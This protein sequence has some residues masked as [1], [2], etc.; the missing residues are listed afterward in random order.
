MLLVRHALT[1][2][3]VLAVSL[4]F[5]TMVGS[6]PASAAPTYAN[7]LESSVV[8][9]TNSTR[10]QHG[11]RGVSGNAC[12]DRMAESW[13]RHLAQTRTLA[14]RQL[15]RVLDQCNRSFVSENLAKYPVTPGMTATQ[16]ARSTVRAWL[17]SPAHRHNLLSFKPRVIGLGV[18]KG[19][20]GRYWYIV[21]NFAR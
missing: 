16:M 11:R 7:R 19:S 13:A 6:S 4:G 21:Q 18:A 17:R 3:V 12:I 14:H 10:R 9:A 15:G 20:N 5:V 1:P 2:L 8:A